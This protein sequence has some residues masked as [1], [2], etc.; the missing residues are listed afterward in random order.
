MS[1]RCID[2][3]KSREDSF[4]LQPKK[5]G[6]RSVAVA[7]CAKADFVRVFLASLTRA[8]RLCTKRVHTR[9]LQAQQAVVRLRALNECGGAGH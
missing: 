1:M 5:S 3:G 7:M 9:A 2:L 8:W 6:D 4:G